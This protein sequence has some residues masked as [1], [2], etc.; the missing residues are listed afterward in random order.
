VKL[1]FARH[2]ESQANVQQVF[3]DQPHGY[4]LTDKGR[5]QARA[6]ADS[7][8]TVGFATRLAGIYCSPILRAAQTARIVGRRL[9]LTPEIEDALCERDVSVLE[10]Q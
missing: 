2:G 5:E 6:W 9:N 10:G 3:W 7:L 8:A 4:G 1:Y